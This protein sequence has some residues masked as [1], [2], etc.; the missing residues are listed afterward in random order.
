[1]RV[2]TST[3]SRRPLLGSC[4]LTCENLGTGAPSYDVTSAPGLGC[5]LGSRSLLLHSGP[6]WA[7]RG[8]SKRCLP[9]GLVQNATAVLGSGWACGAAVAFVSGCTSLLDGAFAKGHCRIAW[10]GRRAFDVES[11]WF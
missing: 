3:I 2:P 10:E 8:R 7:S 1:M 4:S 11:R 6:S 5:Y 9:R